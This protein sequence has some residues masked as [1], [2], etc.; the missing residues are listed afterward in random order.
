MSDYFFNNIKYN[1]ITL[2]FYSLFLNA[3]RN[4]KSNFIFFYFYGILVEV[5][6][7]CYSVQ[8]MPIIPDSKWCQA[9][10]LISYLWNCSSLRIGGFYLKLIL[11]P[12]KYCVI[13]GLIFLQNNRF[14]SDFNWIFDYVHGTHCLILG[15]TN[16]IRLNN[17][18]GDRL[19]IRTNSVIIILFYN[20]ETPQNPLQLAICLLF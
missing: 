2:F 18:V 6:Y 17:W 20:E 16:I 1:K 5:M 15:Q 19:Q 8:H 13:I 4:F 7:A 10:L 9:S 12:R 14:S 11:G 3:K